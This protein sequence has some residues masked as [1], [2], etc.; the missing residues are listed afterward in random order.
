M[1][2]ENSHDRAKGW[3]ELN[4]H[5]DHKGFNVDD[6][7]LA[8]CYLEREAMLAEARELCDYLRRQSSDW[9]EYARLEVGGHAYKMARLLLARLSAGTKEQA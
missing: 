6:A 9:T 2:S 3:A 4:Q 7:N 5:L 1:G 8:R